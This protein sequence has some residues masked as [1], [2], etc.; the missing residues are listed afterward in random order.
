MGHG[1][2]NFLIDSKGL[3]GSNG[4]FDLFQEMLATKFWTAQ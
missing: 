3:S 4:V 2:G 1:E